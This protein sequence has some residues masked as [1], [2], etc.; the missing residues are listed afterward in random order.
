MKGSVERNRYLASKYDP[1]NLYDQL[2]YR[3]NE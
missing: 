2:V 1:N 3:R